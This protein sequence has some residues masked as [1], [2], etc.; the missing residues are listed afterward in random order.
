MTTA[1][2][3]YWT[4]AKLSFQEHF[5]YRANVYME[6]L[7]GIVTMLLTIALWYSLYSISG[8]VEIG[9]YTLP[10]M[11]TYVIG[12][13]FVENILH[14]TWQGDRAMNDINSGTLNNYLLKPMSPLAYWFVNDIALKILMFGFVSVTIA[15]VAVVFSPF[16]VLPASLS[17]FAVFFVLIFLAAFL[18][19]F[20]FHITSMLSF[21]LG[22]TWGVSFILRVSMIVATGGL[23]PLELFP[24]IVR[25]IFLFLPFQ[26]FGY[27]Q[28]QVFFGHFSGEDILWQVVGIVAWTMLFILLSQYIYRK[29]LQA[30]GAYGG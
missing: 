19:F 28:M 1:A 25:E 24:D 20:F 29:G 11:I 12:V 30:Y 4:I 23:V 3:K 15:I 9:G 13:G 10:M 6:M 14:R 22:I 5:A 18:H 2:H 8:Q 21:W 27:A 16:M 7:G 26:Y 17:H